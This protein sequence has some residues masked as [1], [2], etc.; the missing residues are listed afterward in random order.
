MRRRI[1]LVALALAV[2]AAVWWGL[3]GRGEDGGSAYR[4][5]A[6][7]RGNVERIVSATGFLSAIGS[8][9]VGTQVSGII[10]SIDVDY[11]DEV[12]AGQ[13]IAL[14]DTTLL[15]SAVR[16]A[17]AEVM[18]SGAQLR[19]AE[20][21]WARVSRLY[22]QAVLAESELNTSLYQRD[23]ARAA[24]AAAAIRLER[25]RRN[26]DYATI[27]APMAGTIVERNV[28]VGQTVAA[29]LSAPQLFLITDDL[30]R[31]EILTAVD[32]SDIGLIAK[33]QAV[34][35][36]VQ[37]YPDDAFAGVV[38]Q[39]R[40]QPSTQENV[41]TYTVVVEVDNANRRLLPGM[42]ATVDFLI[43]TASDVARV[44]NAALRFQPTEAMLASLRERRALQRGAAGQPGR[45]AGAAGFPGARAA[46]GDRA[47]FWILDE[48][49]EPVPRPVRVG[50][51]D[52][53]YTALPGGELEPG[54][55]VIAGVTTNGAASQSG[56][57]SPF[58]SSQQQRRRGPPPGGGF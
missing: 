55:P 23:T 5:V 49:G 30:R 11:N 16:E 18:R 54:T 52:G 25:A 45:A 58:Q 39:V 36:T 3:A 35:F 10:A 19:Y 27:R 44:P 20:Q 7:D 40:L 47:V 56:V 34:R 9:Q 32:E 42:T 15:V 26:L 22:E 6:V 12:Q 46:A 33:G 53:Q 43:A 50:I 2:A 13:V 29:S 31:M 17:E 38:S 8:V 14:I 37:A 41:V 57:T 4:F 48:S 1:I 28:D 24:V 21:E 51:T